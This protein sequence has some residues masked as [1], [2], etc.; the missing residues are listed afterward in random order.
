METNMIVEEGMDYVIRAPEPVGYWVVGQINAF[1]VMEKPTDEQI[2]NTE[3]L[4]GWEW[5]EE[6]AV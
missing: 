6:F 4:L 1:P 3:E 2:K 5:R